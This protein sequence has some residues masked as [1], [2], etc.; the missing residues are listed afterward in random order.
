MNQLVSKQEAERILRTVP[1]ENGFRFT[2]P[3]GTSTSLTATGLKD[4]AEKLKVVNADSIMYH[5]S[6]GDFQAWITGTLGDQELS[7]RMCF[8]KTGLSS[9]SLRREVGKMVQKRIA[10]LKSPRRNPAVK[11]GQT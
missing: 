7:N 10:E 1:V 8:I 3:N 9:E 4:F 6:R 11:K 2:F 5:Y